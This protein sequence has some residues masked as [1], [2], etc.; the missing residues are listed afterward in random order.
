VPIAELLDQLC[1]C[2][3][4]V[5]GN[6]RALVLL[7]KCFCLVVCVVT[8]RAISS[9]PLTPPSPSALADQQ[10]DNELG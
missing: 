6:L 7:H 9:Y 4:Q 3:S 2:I 1:C 5:D 8:S 10:S